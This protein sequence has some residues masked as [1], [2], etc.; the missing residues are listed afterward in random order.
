MKKDRTDLGVGLS[1]R[2]GS[3]GENQYLFARLDVFQAMAAG[4]ADSLR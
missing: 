2:K 3:V 4:V 1:G